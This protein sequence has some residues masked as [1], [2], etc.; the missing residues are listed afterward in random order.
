MYAL[1]IYTLIPVT[2]VW[3]RS[4]EQLVWVVVPPT[5]TRIRLRYNVRK[6]LSFLFVTVLEGGQGFRITVSEVTE[7]DPKLVSFF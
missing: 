4:R 3:A 6:T 7:E 1:K 2:L 5:V